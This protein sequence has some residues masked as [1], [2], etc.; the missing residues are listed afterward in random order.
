MKKIGFIGLG[1]MGLPMSRNLIERSGQKIY[2][3]DVAEDRLALFAR[4]GG[5]VM[6][7]AED[8]YKECDVIFQILPTH[9]II[10]ESI[11]KAVRYG[12]PGNIVVD[13]S[14][15]APDIITG[16]YEKAKAEG[17]YLLDSPVSGG[18]VLAE[19]GALAIMAGG[20]REAFDSV[21]PLLCCMGSPTYTGKSGSGSLTKLVN[22]MLVGAMVVGLGEAYAFAEKSGLDLE[23][24][25]NATRNGFVGGPMYASKAPKIIS[26]DFTP[27]ARVAVHKKDIINAQNHAAQLG[28]ELPMTDVV[29]D[30]MNWMDENGYI[31]E[32]QSALIRYFEAKMGIDT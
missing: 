14:S 30:V 10:S 27:G 23:L 1:V 12:K 31:N 2:G 7:S 15:T 26:R 5:T 18:D 22:N 29:L 9:A 32:D 17:I 25:F 4:Y 6:E 19:K 20:D 28:I 8:M 3:F 21:E 24:V 16:L 11:E 13:M